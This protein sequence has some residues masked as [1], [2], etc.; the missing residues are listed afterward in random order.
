MCN[1]NVIYK[2]KNLKEEK[3]VTIDDLKR[4]FENTFSNDCSKVFD[5]F[6]E[7]Y[8]SKV[9]TE[10][11]IS[12]YFSYY[13]YLLLQIVKN[14]LENNDVPFSTYS[15]PINAFLNFD[16][17]FDKQGYCLTAKNRNVLIC[18]RKSC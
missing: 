11:D 2:E 4:Y 14:E 3:I 7:I 5:R 1:V 16:I 17:N 18:Y 13:I 8:L 9:V 10:K 15:C 6:V 12:D